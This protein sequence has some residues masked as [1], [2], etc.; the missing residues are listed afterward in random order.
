MNINRNNYEEYFL[1]YADNELTDSEKAEV[2][3]FVKENKDLEE[4]FR[5]I[6]HTIL[7][8]NVN[9]QLTDKSFLLR[10][11]NLF[12]NEE[13]YEEIFVLYHDNELSEKEKLETEN[14][15][16]LHKELKN[17]FDL[18]GMASLTPER[19]VVFDNKKLLYK[20]EKTGK[21]VPVMFW[22]MLTAAVFIGFGLWIT[23]LY[24]GKNVK[25]DKAIV[26]SVPAKKS[27]SIIKNI[28]PDKKP[29][30]VIA[31][32]HDNINTKPNDET[33]II[34]EKKQTTR[35]N[36]NSYVKNIIP[37]K[38]IEKNNANHVH[39]KIK[40]E[41]V[42]NNKIK[43]ISKDEILLI[44]KINPVKTLLQN[45]DENNNEKAE[46]HAE[47]VSYVTNENNASENYVFYDVTTNNFKKTKMGGF[48]KK[49]KRVIVRSNPITRLLSDN[50]QLASN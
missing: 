36:N 25:H 29:A 3:L 22:R 19:S 41:I 44:D 6:H 28:I 30:E 34:K 33:N 5:M 26:H 18:I 46:T 49:I 32:S 13:N 10:N 8:P 14:F 17:E 4:E 20:K 12:I 37:Q 27:T 16:R 45:N 42:Y 11:N 15:L 2:L 39:E 7:K 50:E 48:L 47:T 1:L 43:D 35:K 38:P 23:N 40:D 31:Q 24:F 9:V 21:V